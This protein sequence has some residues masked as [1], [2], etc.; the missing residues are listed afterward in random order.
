MSVISQCLSKDASV[1]DVQLGSFGISSPTKPILKVI[2]SLKVPKTKGSEEEIASKKDYRE[3]R[4]KRFDFQK[5]LIRLF[6]DKKT[7]NGKSFNFHGCKRSPIKHNENIEI[8]FSPAADSANYVGLQSCQRGNSCPHCAEIK[9]MQDKKELEAMRACHL[10]AG[11][12]LIMM[13]LTNGHHI[14][15]ELSFLVDGQKIAVDKLN[16]WI[17]EQKFFDEFGGRVATVRA[18]EVTYGKNGWHP[19]FHF[20]YYLNDDLIER[21]SETGEALEEQQTLR[22]IRNSISEQ[23]QKIC[24]K[25]GLPTP[26]YEIGVDVR[27]GTHASKYVGKFG[28]EIISMKSSWGSS[29][30]LAKGHLKTSHKAPESLADALKLDKGLTP[31]QLLEL[32]HNGDKKA[33]DLFVEY[34]YGTFGT[35][36]L[37]WYQGAKKLYDLEAEI[38]ARK[39]E[40]L[41]LTAQKFDD[42]IIPEDYSFMSLPYG[43]WAAVV[44]CN[45][46]SQLLTAVETDIE[47]GDFEKKRITWAL[48][49][50]C[51]E[52]FLAYLMDAKNNP[53]IIELQ[54]DDEKLHDKACKRFGKYGPELLSA[55]NSI[56][57]L[58]LEKKVIETVPDW[59]LDVPIIQEQEMPIFDGY[60]CTNQI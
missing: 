59:V 12:S 32:A 1:K 34:V 21:D 14:S 56:Q 41:E 18:W 26:D 9:A 57:E 15:D 44:H 22:I 38:E 27:D 4:Q 39:Q 19:H 46:R 8:V 49:N 10:R 47:N 48:I 45:M 29:D 35:A 33:G 40:Q 54:S 7:I 17:S 43:R 36:Q 51:S 50:H 13:T 2:R 53:D 30:E 58:K 25:V 20:L 52:V 55:I 5:T 31:W 37:Y 23:W 3:A 24:K 11:G 6:R 42:N 16:K 28:D 60:Y